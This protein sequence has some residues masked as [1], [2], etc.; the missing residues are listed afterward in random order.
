MPFRV[1]VISRIVFVSGQS[2]DIRI[3]QDLAGIAVRQGLR[4]LGK[5]VGNGAGVGDRKPQKTQPVLP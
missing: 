4:M 3:D 5:W 2:T 1:V